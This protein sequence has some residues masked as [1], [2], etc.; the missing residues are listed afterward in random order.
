MCPRTV[1]TQSK[2]FRMSLTK[3]SVHNVGVTLCVYTRGII[4]FV[5]GTKSAMSGSRSMLKR[6]V[7]GK[8]ATKNL[9]PIDVEEFRTEILDAGTRLADLLVVEYPK[10]SLVDNALFGV[11]EVLECFGLEGRWVTSWASSARD[12]FLATNH[13]RKVSGCL[14]F[15]GMNARFMLFTLRCYRLPCRR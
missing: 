14:V 2:F 5:F 6:K 13:V 7:V 12:E 1:D 3:Y 10:A 4:D 9:S 8:T 11:T 15:I